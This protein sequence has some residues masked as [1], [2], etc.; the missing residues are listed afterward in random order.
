MEGSPRRNIEWPNEE[1]EK[2][3]S[4][5]GCVVI[6]HS[7]GLETEWCLQ[8][9][10]GSELDVYNRK[11]IPTLNQFFTLK[12]LTMVLKLRKFTIWRRIA[13]YSRRTV[14]IFNG[15]DTNCCRW[16]LKL[17]PPRPLA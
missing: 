1:V 13:F 10:P 15:E 2:W 7:C 11:I 6:G 12:P 17:P 14:L 5:V 16:S 9:A 8:I 4:V 3:F